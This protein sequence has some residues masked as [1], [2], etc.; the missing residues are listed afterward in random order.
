MKGT[1][2]RIL[3]VDDNPAI[4]EDLKEVLCPNKLTVI[5][6]EA[7]A[8]EEELFSDDEE[9]DSFESYV[10]D[11]D[12]DDAF[13]GDE[14]IAM[15]E[16]A[17]GEG[18]PYALIFMDV[19][20]PPGI[21]G[22]QTIHD[23][24]ERYPDIEIIICTAYSDY[25][26]DQILEKLGSTDSLL[27]MKKPFDTVAVRQMALSLTKKWAM[28]RQNKSDIQNLEGKIS[29]RTQDL[30]KMISNL[31]SL[32]MKAE[33]ATIS[34]EGVLSSISHGIQTPLSGILGIADMLLDTE[35]DADQRD[36]AE[37]IK[38][39]GDSLLTVV[40]DVLQYSRT[41]AGNLDLE[42]IEFNIR[43]AIENT[44]DLV[45]A[46]A[47]EKGLETATLVH[48]DV[49]ETLIGDPVRLRQVLLILASNA[50]GSTDTGEIVISVQR[51]L[52]KPSHEDPERN[53]GHAD[54]RFEVSDTGT[55]LSD[56]K[57]Q[58]L[59]NL[60][61]D[62]EINSHN[63]DV[64]NGTGLSLCRQLAELMKGKIGLDSDEGMGSTFWFTA[65]FATTEAPDY[66]ILPTAASMSGARCLLVGD[67][68]T[69]R[70]VLSLYINQWGGSCSEA[71][72]EVSAV[73]QLHTALP[74]K[75][76]DAAIVDVKNGDKTRYKE[77]ADSIR[78]HKTLD[79][80][81]LICL[82][83]KAKRGDAKELKRHGYCA[84]LSKPIRHSHLYNCLLMIKVFRN[85]SI[86]VKDDQIITKHF[87]D[88]ISA[89]RY[90]F[91]VVEDNPVNTNTLV[92]M[93][94]NL[95]ISC[96]V[97]RNGKEAL[98]A[99]SKRKYDMILMDCHMPEMDGYEA[100]R[101]IRKIEQEEITA[102][103]QSKDK[104]RIPI[105]ALTASAD[106]EN[107]D[108]CYAAGMD[109]FLTKPIKAEQMANLVRKHL[110]PE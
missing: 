68:P 55:G 108:K 101:E 57:K 62:P 94:N 52:T 98:S 12:I 97:A 49:P 22:I 96:D 65:R 17:E 90:R 69:S 82:T 8:L 88:E 79:S 42:E 74:T 63:G 9:K 106:A 24:W 95:T 44:A 99:C 3:I 41:E 56:E 61:T 14:A 86:A 66:Q 10:P 28:V 105:F 39:A 18:N 73:E 92:R 34:K 19:R 1:S 5:D 54:L 29:N 64:N 27:F 71:V 15:V 7:T 85:K 81:R 31:E 11:Y 87:F 33:S 16:K 72:N 46:N 67:N 89:A 13:Q 84:Y 21:D 26:W 59:N 2:N 80:L 91:L 50:V 48:A 32:K 6:E 38:V 110:E 77:I 40:D 30:K 109:D 100:T 23:I 76:F 45:S 104:A 107:R 47:H 43:T 60:L 58:H 35:L 78:R 70:K 103:G 83:P 36:L 51:D 53:N 37:T 25:S 75:P 93:L 20:M 102:S 4:H